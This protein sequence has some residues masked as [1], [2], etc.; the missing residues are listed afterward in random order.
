MV[1][2]TVGLSLILA[3]SLIYSGT[4]QET[5]PCIPAG[6][7]IAETLKSRLQDPDSILED[8][9]YGPVQEWCF[10]AS[11][12]FSGAFQGMEN[13]PW[14]IT[15]WQTSGVTDFSSA[16]DG[17]TNFNQ[18]ISGW[19]TRDAKNF[20]YMFR[21]AKSF[22]QDIGIWRVSKV[23]DFTEMFRGASSFSGGL[24]NDPGGCYSEGCSY[25]GYDESCKFEF[26]RECFCFD[27][28]HDI[29]NYLSGYEE[30]HKWCR[31][32]FFVGCWF[33]YAGKK[34]DRMF[35][36]AT[37]FDGWVHP[38]FDFIG[39]THDDIFTDTKYAPV[40]NY[41]GCANFLFNTSKDAGYAISL[42]GGVEAHRARRLTM[43]IP[44][45]FAILS[46]FSSL[47]IIVS[48]TR[49]KQEREKTQNF[50]F[51]RMLFGLSFFDVVSSFGYFL[52]DWPIPSER[53]ALESLNRQI[54]DFVQ[55]DRDTFPH[56]CFNHFYHEYWYPFASGTQATCTIQG[57]I[58]Q[59]GL[60]GSML[61]TAWLSLGFLLMVKYNWRQQKLMKLERVVVAF[62]FLLAF[63]SAIFLAVV[64]QFN[65][66]STGFCWI[67]DFPRNIELS[68][69]AYED[70]AERFGDS[71]VRGEKH[72]MT[73]Q[74]VFAQIWV[75]LVL[76]TIII[77][78]LMVFF[79]VRSTVRRNKLYGEESMRGKSNNEDRQR[80][81]E[82]EKLVMKKGFGY[83]GESTSR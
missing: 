40:N 10:E 60:I 25:H 47:Y 57:F 70:F 29:E 79:H 26:P 66:V 30:T 54:Q 13:I 16:F 44:R 8:P 38:G 68:G 17:C 42:E 31:D 63:G 1:V 74:L 37:S 11:V 32:D 23:E 34:Y 58:I 75:G 72:L 48:L 28:C 82:K 18:D 2:K 67:G 21:N 3:L 51:F 52:M 33:T 27:N 46:M 76:L 6:T 61:C 64:D 81:S 59:V 49:T 45:V 77:S 53:P 22:D 43:I 9:V 73:Y 39:A 15:A 78:L 80:L 50:W 65:P 56:S 24:G 36:G 83:G 20:S 5:R 7:R 12:D 41:P 35:Q 4:S 55:A 69:V 19:D 71:L 62:T 14:N